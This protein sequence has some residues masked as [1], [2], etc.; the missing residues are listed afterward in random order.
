MP[1]LGA[2]TL[3]TAGI[4]VSSG[5][6]TGTGLGGT[7]GS[8][9]LEGTTVSTGG[10]R[11]SRALGVSQGTLRYTQAPSGMVTPFGTITMPSRM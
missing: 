7:A 2:G 8:I 4:T 9:V 5:A 10:R 3:S 11:A 1:G 6:A